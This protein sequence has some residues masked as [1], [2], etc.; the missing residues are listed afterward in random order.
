MEASGCF[1]KRGVVRHSKIGPLKTATAHQRPITP[2]PRV[3]PSLQHP[4]KATVNCSTSHRPVRSVL[5]E[6]RETANIYIK[7]GATSHAQ[8][9]IGDH[10]RGWAGR[11]GVCSEG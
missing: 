1:G 9:R 10:L 3:H 4:P 11:V 2:T 8:D 7:S 6:L 5:W